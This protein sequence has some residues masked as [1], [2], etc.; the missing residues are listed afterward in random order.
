MIV[1][2]IAVCL[3]SMVAFGLGFYDAL[4]RDKPWF[5]IDAFFLLC[6]GFLLAALVTAWG[7][8]DADGPDSDD[9]FEEGQKVEIRQYQNGGG[10]PEF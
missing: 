6:A 7:L 3:V 8:N 1:A 4:I 9:P 10:R 2:G 5:W